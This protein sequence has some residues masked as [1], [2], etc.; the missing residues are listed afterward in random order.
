MRVLFLNSI[1]L[2][3]WVDARNCTLYRDD[4]G[5]HEDNSSD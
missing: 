4:T 5:R 3:C 2:K 1:P